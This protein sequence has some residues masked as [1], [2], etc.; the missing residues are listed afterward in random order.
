MAYTSDNVGS[1][2][3]LAGNIIYQATQRLMESKPEEDTDVL[4]DAVLLMDVVTSYFT[5]DDPKFR[6]EF[7][8]IAEARKNAKVKGEDNKL[9]PY[10]PGFA[11]NLDD[12]FRYKELK[13]M[14][15][16]MCRA[17]KFTRVESPTAEWKPR[18]EAKA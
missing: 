6:T 8:A 10:E 12:A 15:R 5:E 11:K 4:D 2:T 14:F 1:A 18:A 17:G 3:Y 7:E 13:A 9:Y 16:S